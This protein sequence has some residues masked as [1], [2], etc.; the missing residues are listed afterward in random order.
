MHSCTLMLMQPAE[1][2][3]LAMDL[4]SFQFLYFINGKI[5]SKNILII[6]IKIINIRTANYILT[7]I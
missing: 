2:I 3:D 1:E 6:Q 4:S 5:V 7:V